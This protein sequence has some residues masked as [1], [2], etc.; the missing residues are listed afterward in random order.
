MNWEDQNIWVDRGGRLHTLMHAFRGQ[1]TTY[2]APGCVAA[3]NG[4]WLPL[5]CTSVG[6]HAFSVDGAHWYISPVRAYTATVAYEDGSERAFRARE[7]PHLVFAGSGPGSGD[8][9]WFVSAVG[10]PGPGGNTGEVGQD[11]SFTLLQE[12]GQA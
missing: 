2:P 5:G 11:H 12:L 6:G 10:D 7:R 3:A 9:T 1:N 8:P 4:T